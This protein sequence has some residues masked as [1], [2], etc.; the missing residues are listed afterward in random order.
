MKASELAAKL[1]EMPDCE[2]IV[3]RFERDDS[4]Y[5]ASIKEFD[6]TGIWQ[7]SISEKWVELSMKER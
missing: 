7:F 2:V 5:G 3:K 4:T 6:I 1:L